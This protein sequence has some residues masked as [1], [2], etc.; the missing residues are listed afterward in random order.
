MFVAM[1][2]TSARRCCTD[3]ST[4][5]FSITRDAK[6]PALNTTVAAA[7]A[8]KESSHVHAQQKITAATQQ[9]GASLLAAPRG[10]RHDADKSVMV[11]ARSARGE[12]KMAV[13]RSKAAHRG[14]MAGKCRR[15]RQ[16]CGDRTFPCRQR[17]PNRHR[18]VRLPNARQRS[19]VQTQPMR[20]SAIPAM[21]MSVHASV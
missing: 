9:P 17:T 18:T 16:R 1:D 20:R 15:G 3:M 12:V 4:A 6:P 2:A 14:G 5:P 10:K 19:G 7:Q 21:E 8:R 13:P 11:A